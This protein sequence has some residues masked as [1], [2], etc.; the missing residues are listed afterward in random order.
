MQGIY[1]SLVKIGMISIIIDIKAILLYA[2]LLITYVLSS[3][4]NASLKR[5]LTISLK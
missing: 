2:I 4:N 3:I 1:A 5:L